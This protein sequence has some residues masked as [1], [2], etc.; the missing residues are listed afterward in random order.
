VYIESC[1]FKNNNQVIDIWKL[2]QTL[3]QFLDL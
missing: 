2:G 1:D 3:L